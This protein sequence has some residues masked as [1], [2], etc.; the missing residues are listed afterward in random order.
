[1]PDTGASRKQQISDGAIPGCRGPVVT[2]VAFEKQVRAICATSGQKR[3]S[4]LA[5]S[6]CFMLRAQ[7]ASITLMPRRR[8]ATRGRPV[9]RWFAFPRAEAGGGE[10]R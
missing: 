4:V 6:P 10:G 1:M 9:L 5:P 2:G 8:G 7:G 3:R